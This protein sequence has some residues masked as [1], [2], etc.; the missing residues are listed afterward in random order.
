[1]VVTNSATQKAIVFVKV[2]KKVI[3]NYKATSLVQYGLYNSHKKFNDAGPR[4]AK[5]MPPKYVFG[6]I[7]WKVA[8]RWKNIEHFCV[9]NFLTVRSS[10]TGHR[11]QAS[12]M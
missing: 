2:R 5:V 3:D 1:M 9:Y 4:I 12:K 7:S 6:S 8:T 10:D 11:G